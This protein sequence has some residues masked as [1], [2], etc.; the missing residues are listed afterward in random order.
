VIIHYVLSLE[1]V[2]SCRPV[3]IK[4]SWVERQMFHVLYFKDDVDVP[5]ILAD[6]STS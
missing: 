2:P 4:S 5:A 6:L 3:P 1:I